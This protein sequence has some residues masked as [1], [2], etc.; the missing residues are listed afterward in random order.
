[1]CT[2]HKR[3]VSLIALS[4]LL[5]PGGCGRKAGMDHGV[6]TFKLGLASVQRAGSS[7][8]ELALGDRILVGDVLTT[9]EQSAAVI[10][11]SE[12]CLIR[13]DEKTSFRINKIE[14]KNLEMF[15]QKGSVMSKLIRDENVGLIIKTRTALAA[16]R[17]TEFSVTYKDGLSKVAVSRGKVQTAAERHDDTGK[18]LAAVEK[19]V[20]VG[21]GNTVE[22]TE[23]PKKGKEELGALELKLREITPDEKNALRKIH[24]MPVIDTPEKKSREEMEE[25]RKSVLDIENEIDNSLKDEASQE[26]G[27]DQ[28]KALLA[29]KDRTMEDIRK[30]FNRIDEISLYNGRVIRG[31]IISRGENFKVIT[32]ERM[33]TVP[34][35]DIMNTRVVK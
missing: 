16:V 19:E 27:Q 13:V 12:Q 20:P 9:G 11:F 26:M 17:G 25:I 18:I 29:K 10:Q 5:I 24:A 4:F 3:V 7:P 28:V 14:G 30:T 35:K 33:L 32:P 21:A 8:A 6:I 34:Q 2:M 22:V 1:M 15:V 23:L 31:A